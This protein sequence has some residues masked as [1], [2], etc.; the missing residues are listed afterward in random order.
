M[1]NCTCPGNKPVLIDRTK[2]GNPAHHHDPNLHSHVTVTTAFLRSWL[3]SGDVIK[4]IIMLR[5]G[6]L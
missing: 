1:I 6:Q 3:I 5:G 2:C 4:I